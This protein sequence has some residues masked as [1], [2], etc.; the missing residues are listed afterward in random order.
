MNIMNFKMEQANGNY[1]KLLLIICFLFDIDLL[2]CNLLLPQEVK[3]KI[4]RNAFL[5]QNLGFIFKISQNFL[6]FPRLC[7]AAGIRYFQMKG[8]NFILAQRERARG[9][10]IIPSWKEQGSEPNMHQFYRLLSPN[11]CYSQLYVC[12]SIPLVYN[13]FT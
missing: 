9:I 6:P 2:I 12:H 5:E 10:K 1:D 8:Y 13:F 11:V 3:F 4:S 7:V